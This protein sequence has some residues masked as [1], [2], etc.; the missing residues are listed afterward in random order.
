MI[1]LQF[2]I[3]KAQFQKACFWSANLI[4]ALVFAVAHLPGAMFLYNVSTPL[5]LPI[6][7]IVEVIAL[8]TVVGIFAG[9][10]F[11]RAGLLGALGVHF[12][13]DV[14]W[15]VLWPPLMGVLL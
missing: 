8:N 1:I 2:L 12:W 4:A 3:R 11:S 6:P 7:L 14:V 5:D 15:N 13:A 9:W 10:Q